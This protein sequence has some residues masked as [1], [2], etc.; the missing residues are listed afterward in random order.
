MDHMYYQGMIISLLVCLLVGFCVA[1]EQNPVVVYIQGKGSTLTEDTNG[2]YVI[3]IKETV[4]YIH[5]QDNYKSS[6]EPIQTLNLL[7]EPLNAALVQSGDDIEKTSM[8][9]V[10]NITISE[11][12]NVLKLTIEPLKFYDGEILKSFQDVSGELESN[13][14]ED[15]SVGVYLE[16]PAYVPVN[17]FCTC[18][19]GCT[20]VYIAGVGPACECTRNCLGDCFVGC[21]AFS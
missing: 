2:T 3:T 5:F 4:P 21:G 13:T 19:L 7:T 16:L 17:A 12:N 8:I 14:T 6:L 15:A 20:D 11:D 9:T 1:E 10:S 18:P